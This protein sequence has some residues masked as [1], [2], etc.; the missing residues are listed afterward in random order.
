MQPDLVL[1]QGMKGQI[2][3]DTIDAEKFR[4]ELPAFG[5]MFASFSGIEAFRGKRIGYCECLPSD[6]REQAYHDMNC[7]AMLSYANRLAGYVSSANDDD[8]RRT[9]EDAIAW[10]RF[11]A[12]HPVK[13]VAWY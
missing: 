9:L 12:Q 8:E 4:K 2:L 6:L 3:V 11:W 13:M 1:I 7:D 5:G 10:L